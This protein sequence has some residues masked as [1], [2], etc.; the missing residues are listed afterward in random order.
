MISGVIDQDGMILAGEGFALER[1]GPG[2]YAI[3]F[4]EPA[5]EFPV[6][7][8]GTDYWHDLVDWEA[9]RML[10]EGN[11]SPEDLDLFTVTDDPEKVRDLLMAAAHR[12]AR[13]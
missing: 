9:V 13:V 2:V 3:R 5:P 11:I 12:Q 1:A 7:L 8:V 4:L 10:G 6:V